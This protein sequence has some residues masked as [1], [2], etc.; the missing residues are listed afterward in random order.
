MSPE[1]F[2]NLDNNDTTQLR[3]S[4]N[5]T[6]S[7]FSFKV[8]FAISKATNPVA[9]MT[10]IYSQLVSFRR[11][12]MKL[13]IFLSRQKF[14]FSQS[15]FGAF[16]QLFLLP[17]IRERNHR[18][19]PVTRPESFH[20][21]FTFQLLSQSQFSHRKVQAWVQGYFFPL[22]RKL[23]HNPKRSFTLPVF[24]RRYSCFHD[25]PICAQSV[26]IQQHVLCWPSWSS[27]NRTS[28]SSSLAPAEKIFFSFRCEK[29]SSSTSVTF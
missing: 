21:P 6:S 5:S 1:L 24:V 10:W 8:C 18:N 29:I 9:Y 7:A 16:V 23:N 14:R 2:P 4:F 17:V 25:A 3:V 11:P 13:S 19:L 28:H 15:F 26:V 27:N 22:Q 12:W 20:P